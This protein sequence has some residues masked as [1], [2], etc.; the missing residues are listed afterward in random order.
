LITAASGT[1]D[2]I[3]VAGREFAVDNAMPLGY[4]CGVAGEATTMDKEEEHEVFVF[5]PVNMRR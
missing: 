4:R 3:S 2:G 5:H 1:T